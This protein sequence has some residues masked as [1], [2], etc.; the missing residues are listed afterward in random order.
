V[1]Q[2][3]EAARRTECKNKMKQLGLALHNFHDT[4]QH[5]PP[6]AASSGNL[7]FHVYILPQME[8]KNIYDNMSLTANYDASPNSTYR[9][10]NISAFLCPSGTQVTANSP[11][12]DATVHYYGN[13]GPRGTN[14]VTAAAYTPTPGTASHGAYSKNGPLGINTKN[15]FRDF[16]DGTSNTIMVGEISWKNANCYRAW[17]RGWDGNASSSAKNVVNAINAQAYTS[18]NFNDVSFGSEHPGGAQFLMGDGSIHFINENVSMPIYYST[19]SMN[20]GEVQT[21]IQ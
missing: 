21:A 17:T 5:L 8:Q 2:A 18:N 19:A 10:Q 6:G 9:T 16:T 4:F 20:G 15:G 7:G 13:L 1:Q 11:T 3:R 12:T 14:P